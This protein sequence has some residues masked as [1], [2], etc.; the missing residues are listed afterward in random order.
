LGI[1]MKAGRSFARDI[2][3][4]LEQAYILNET[5]ANRFTWDT[6]IDK[7]I[8]WFDDDETR[9]GQVIGI[10]EDFHFQSLHKA[11]EPLIFQVLPLEFNYMLVK[12]STE[13]IEQ[14]LAVLGNKWR[15][16][17][18]NHT[19]EYAFL[20]D[21]FNKLYQAEEKMQSIFKYF[22]SM[23]IFIACLGLLGLASFSAEQR[24]KEIGIRKV[25]GASAIGI[26]KLLSKEYLKLVLIANIL[27]W[28]VAIFIMNNWLQEFA[29]RT[30]IGI[31]T[32]IFAGGLALL[33][34]LFTV[35]FQAVKA[36]V[37]NPV[38]ALRYE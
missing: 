2:S 25:L 24:T 13:D 17:D 16:F 11:I 31:L 23:A 15:E 1:K 14:T 6:G 4:D 28:P 21:N 32:F 29:Y 3:T 34:A 38:Q 33:I 22:T 12:I 10:C 18:P 26:M 19:F 30:N 5:A 9:R 37:A 20:D 8:V 35:S 7:E 27:A 36:A